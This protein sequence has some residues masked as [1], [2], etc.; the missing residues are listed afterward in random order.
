MP[1]TFLLFLLA[2]P[3]GG[4]AVSAAAGPPAREAPR[5][6]MAEARKTALERV[7]GTVQKS[8]LEREGGKLLYSFDVLDAQGRIME[9]HVDAMT[10]AILIVEVERPAPR[11]K[12]GARRH[13]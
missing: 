6:T 10:G 3:L 1:R 8:E 2:L 9:I 4:V 7:P 13:K 12:A 5:V 11:P